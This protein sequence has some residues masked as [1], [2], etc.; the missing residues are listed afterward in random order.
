MGQPTQ[1]QPSKYFRPLQYVQVSHH[2]RSPNH[3]Q[4]CRDQADFYHVEEQY[5]PAYMNV[6]EPKWNSQRC[7]VNYILTTWRSTCPSCPWGAACAI[8]SRTQAKKRINNDAQLILEYTCAFVVCLSSVAFILQTLT[9]SL[10]VTKQWLQPQPLPKCMCH[11]TI[12][13]GSHT[14]T[15]IILNNMTMSNEATIV[16][17]QF[18]TTPYICHPFNRGDIRC[19]YYGSQLQKPH[20]CMKRYEMF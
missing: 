16:Y 9:T 2:F 14:F 4:Q 5:N 1:H 18:S 15:F 19:R 7:M 11:L 20:F 10:A 17:Q 8:T 3:V 13:Y 6:E 12:E